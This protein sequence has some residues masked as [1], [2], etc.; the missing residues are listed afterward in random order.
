[1]RAMKTLIL[2]TAAFLLFAPLASAQQDVSNTELKFSVDA[3]QAPIER[4]A[5]D[6]FIIVNVEYCYT[7]PGLNPNDGTVTATV[8]AGNSPEWLQVDG[9]ETFTWTPDQVVPAGEPTCDDKDTTFR[10]MP[11][12][13]APFGETGDV[14]IILK[15]SEGDM[16]TFKSVAGD[17]T[18]T[19][20]ITVKTPDNP[21]PGAGE[22]GDGGNNNGGDSDGETTEESPL[23]APFITILALVGL[24]ALRRRR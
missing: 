20:T 16:G 21:F 8:E 18:E 13:T 24:A 5:T 4:N 10:A 15:V 1:M 7:G 23:P 19:V 11:L 2:A 3:P 6:A 22:G 17:R 14:E 12:G 9:G